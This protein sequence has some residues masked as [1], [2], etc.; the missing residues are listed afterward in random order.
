MISIPNKNPLAYLEDEYQSHTEKLL[1]MEAEMQEM[2]NKK[3]DL[4]LRKMENLHQENLEILEREQRYVSLKKKE[5]ISLQEEFNKEKDENKINNN[6][7]FDNS[8]QSPKSPSL[9]STNSHTSSVTSKGKKK[10]FVINILDQIK[11][12]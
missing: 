5:L 3:I 10:S 2:F 4:Q 7:V 6:D 12:K 8:F 11:L 9:I 1:K